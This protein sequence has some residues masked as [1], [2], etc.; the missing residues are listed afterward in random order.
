MVPSSAC[1]HCLQH[2]RPSLAAR[3]DTSSSSETNHRDTTSALMA[4]A[5]A[6]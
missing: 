3:P 2:D 5:L 4:N 1:R 6:A